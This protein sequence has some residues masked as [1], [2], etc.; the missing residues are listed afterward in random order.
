M[1][2]TIAVMTM[3]QGTTGSLYSSQHLQ[4]A[5]SIE[6]LRFGRAHQF[7][8]CCGSACVVDGLTVQPDDEG[9]TRFLNKG[10]VMNTTDNPTKDQ[11]TDEYK[12]ESIKIGDVYLNFRLRQIP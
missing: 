5:T 4:A 6:D 7:C 3:Q 8:G 10:V 12:V 9:L 11:S 1:T 2:E